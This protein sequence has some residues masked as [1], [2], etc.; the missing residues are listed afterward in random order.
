MIRLA[1]R[2]RLRAGGLVGRQLHVLALVLVLVYV[3][4]YVGCIASLV[5]V[6][7]LS[8]NSVWGASSVLLMDWMVVWALVLMMG[9]AGSNSIQH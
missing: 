4:S 2:C 6:L 8:W 7:I 9:R 5:A 1:V 3:P